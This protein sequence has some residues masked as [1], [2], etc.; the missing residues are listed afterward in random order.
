MISTGTLGET[1]ANVKRLFALRANSLRCRL[2][3]MVR[4]VIKIIMPVAKQGD[5][6]ASFTTRWLFMDVADAIGIVKKATGQRAPDEQQTADY[7]IPRCGPSP[8]RP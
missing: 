1:K 8:R 7:L 3:L 6:E 4:D 2:S 5:L